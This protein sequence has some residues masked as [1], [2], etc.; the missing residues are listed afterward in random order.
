MRN[1]LM[2]MWVCVAVMA[3]V[4]VGVAAGLDIAVGALFVLPCL[5]MMGVM[6]WMMVRMTRHG[7]GHQRK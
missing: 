5:L 4:I 2:M 7:G 3:V 6:A 1:H